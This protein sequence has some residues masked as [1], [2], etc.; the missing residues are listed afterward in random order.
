MFGSRSSPRKPLL[1][2]REWPWHR[3]EFIVF[4][5]PCRTQPAISHLYFPTIQDS[6]RA[7]QTPGMGGSDA[8]LRE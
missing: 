1:L 5:P 7:T 3:C 2:G 4:F 6:T 8:Q